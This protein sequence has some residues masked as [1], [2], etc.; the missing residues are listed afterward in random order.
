MLR[1]DW[2]SVGDLLA[3][4]HRENGSTS[5]LE[6]RG[7]GRTWLG[8]AW[9]SG[10][11]QVPTGAAKRTLWVT[12]PSADLAEW[13][14]RVGPY[15]VVR[16]ALLLRGRRLA[17]LADQL[18]GGEPDA[19]MRIE[20]AN[21]VEAAPLTENRG[22]ALTTARKRSAARVFPIG[23]PCAAYA[24]DRGAFRNVDGSLV[25]SQRNEGGRCWLPLLV[26]WEPARNR[27][28]VN[29]RL[30]TVT[31]KSR[32]CPAERAVAARIS[33]GRDETLVIYRSLAR[34]AIRAFLGHQTRARFLVALFDREG[35][36][37]PI[38]K[39]DD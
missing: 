5:R 13:S 22:L 21:G 34:P 23:L 33:W 14:F 4:D 30:L 10:L 12:N 11:G 37:E 38:V 19:A 20:L 1:A 31:E 16:T 18:E 39:I 28:P 32:I 36:V 15:R 8:P 26:S 3:V 17:L 24:T 9:N 29:W 27:R 6:L 35:N 25:L 7:L 2:S